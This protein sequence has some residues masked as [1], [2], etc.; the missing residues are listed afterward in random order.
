ME[1]LDLKEALLNNMWNQICSNPHNTICLDYKSYKDIFEASSADSHVGVSLSVYKSHLQNYTNIVNILED[2]YPEPNSFD[3]YDYSLQLVYRRVLFWGYNGLSLQILNQK[4]LSPKTY[5]YNFPHWPYY[6]SHQ[7]SFSFFYVP[8]LLY[9]LYTGIIVFSTP[10][11][12]KNLFT[13]KEK[14]YE[15]AMSFFD[16]NISSYLQDLL[17]IYSLNIGIIQELYKIYLNSLFPDELNNFTKLMEEYGKKQPNICSR[18]LTNRLLEIIDS[19]YFRTSRF[20]KEFYKNLEKEFIDF[21]DEMNREFTLLPCKQSNISSG[22]LSCSGC[23]FLL[24]HKLNEFI[25]KVQSSAQHYSKEEYDLLTDL[26]NNVNQYIL[27]KKETWDD[28][29]KK[30]KLIF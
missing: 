22:E 4:N 6:Y 23:R 5:I 26:Y 19:T 17:P 1:I 15:H 30:E 12:F 3:R 24:D 29:I 11:G 21:F 7:F 28:I 13:F 18:G 2:S 16:K 27:D 14:V 10:Y 9:P 25:S 8:S 20:Q